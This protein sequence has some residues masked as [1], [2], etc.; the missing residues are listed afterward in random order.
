MK[1]SKLFVLLIVAV[2]LLALAYRSSHRRHVSPPSG[3]GKKVLPGL[4][5]EAVARVEIARDNN[6]PIVIVRGET[7]W[8]VTNLFGYPADMAKLRNNLLTLGEMKVGDLQRGMN[9]DTNAVTLVDLQA[10]SGKP[11]ATLRLGKQYQ[12]SG[13][14]ASWRSPAGGRYLSVAGDKR[15]FLVK[16]SL[17]DFD[18]DA[19]D[20]VSTQLLNLPSSDIQTVELSSPT[21]QVLTLS[22][23]TGSLQMPGLA[24]NEEL[25]VSQT[26]GIE[27]AF[28]NLTFANVA[29]PALADAQTGLAAPHLFR[30]TLKN[31]DVYTAR[32]GSSVSTNQTD[33]YVRLSA[34]LSPGTNVAQKAEY[35]TRQAENEQ[36]FGKWIYLISSYTA[37]NM[38]RA[39][40]DL[41]KP[42]VVTTN[43]TAVAEAPV[44]K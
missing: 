12:R 31:G 11:L 24:T 27:S 37:D 8:S 36:K 43:E 28:G 32:I 44:A 3:I 29:N 19:K 30:V 42:K 9:L 23:A 34:T 5:L 17:T 41:V 35:A 40:A 16:E 21:G 1:P 4:N 15:V 38:T 22:R 7:G 10:A 39:R 2:A 14:E 26:Y 6:A 13:G 25:N 33:R 20:W 18:G